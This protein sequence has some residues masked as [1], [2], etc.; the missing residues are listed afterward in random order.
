MH[1]NSTRQVVT[2]KSK[3]GTGYAL[4]FRAYG[5]REFVTLG[6]SADGWTAARAETEL[7]NVLADIRRGIW[8]PAR[9]AAVEEPVRRD[10]TFHQ[11]ASEWFAGVE[12]GLSKNTR[13]DYQWR[14]S[15]HLLPYFADHRL[16]TITVEEVD[17]YRVHKER[18]RAGLERL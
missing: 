4:R 16:S 2:R 18:D 12:L 5:R 3:R 15:K 13:V 1:R 8:Q 9:P 10:P 14:L 11:F 17:R 6:D 7:A